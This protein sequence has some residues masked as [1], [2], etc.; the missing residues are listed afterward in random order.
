[1]VVYMWYLIDMHNIDVIV[2][3]ITACWWSTLYK[4]GK[5][6]NSSIAS[7]IF[8]FVWSSRKFKAINSIML[9]VASWISCLQ[10]ALVFFLFS[11]TPIVIALDYSL[12]DMA[13]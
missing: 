4:C 3:S 7:F 13:Y 6:T 10:I 9:F 1:M 8:V 11:R 5:I 2:S 12:F